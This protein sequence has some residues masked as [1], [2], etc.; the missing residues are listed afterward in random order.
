MAIVALER[1]QPVQAK[2][3]LAELVARAGS[4]DVVDEFTAGVLNLLGLSEEAARC[5]AR[6]LARHP[7]RIE[8]FLLW[9]NAMKAAGQG[10]LAVARFQV[11]TETAAEDDLFAVA[12][13]G[14]LNLGARPTVLQSALRRVRERIAL[15]P[16]K[17]FLYRLAA[18][19]LEAM[20]RM[21]QVT[22]VLEQS[23]VVAGE[24]RGPLLR[25][26]M[27]A[28]NADGKTDQA[29]AF[30]RT[31]MGLGE[32]VPPQV[33][34]DLGEALIK[35]DQLAAANRVF[36][37]ASMDADFTAIQQ[38]VA[39]AYETADM[40]E[41]ADR[42]IRELLIGQPD[43]VELLIFSGGLCEQI[44]G[45]SRAFEQ[46]HRAAEL[47]LRRLPT[48][49]QTT[50]ATTAP[51][52]GSRRKQ[53]ERTAVN[54]DEMSQYFDS[55]C[56][57]L[58][59]S[60]RSKALQERLIRELRD[61][62]LREIE[63]LASRRMATSSLKQ[64]PRLDGLAKFL[65][66]VAF[67][68]HDPEMADEID[69]KLLAIYSKDAGLLSEAIE[70]RCEWGLYARASALAGRDAAGPVPA[71][72]LID[73]LLSDRER[74]RTCVAGGKVEP[75]IALRLLPTLIM[76]GQ[77]DLARQLVGS[78]RAQ[79]TKP[80]DD[81]SKA[82][83][84]AAV[85]LEDREAIAAWAQTSLDLCGKDR[86]G[87]SMARDIEQTLRLSWN[88]LKPEE[89]SGLIQR[90]GEL[91]A[92]LES[93]GR[94]SMDLL[95]LRLAD[96]AKMPLANRDE[97]I[98]GAMKDVTL[99]ADALAELLALVPASDRPAMLE[100]LVAARKP[101]TQRQFLLSMIGDLNVDED[102]PLVSAV[103]RAFRKAPKSR[104][105]GESGYM[106]LTRARWYQNPRLPKS[107]LKVAEVLLG[108]QPEDPAVMTVVAVARHHGGR[109]VE[110]LSLAAE[111][112]ETITSAKELK[113]DDERMLAE[114]GGIMSPAELDA[115]VG[116][117]K[118]RQNLEGATPGLSYAR[119]ALLLA[120]NRVQEAVAALQEGF[121]LAPEQS[122][123]SRRL[124][125]VMKE[126]GRNVELAE[127][128]AAHLT[129]STIMQ[130]YQ[131]MTLVDTYVGLGNLS[132]ALKAAR[133]L[134]GPLAPIH[135][136]RIAA[137]MDDHERIVKVLRRF[138]IQ[139]RN[140]RRFY[141]P[142]WPEP[143]SEGGMRGFLARLD[144]PRFSRDRIFAALADEP[145]AE[146]EFTCLLQAGAPGRHDIRGL[147]EGLVRA[148]QSTGHMDRLLK[149]LLDANRR[150]AVNAKDQLTIL[151]IAQADPKAIP[152]DLMGCVDRMLTHADPSDAEALVTLARLYMA[153]GNVDR[154]RA[155]LGWVLASDRLE[156]RGSYRE[157]SRFAR[158][159]AYVSTFRPEE[160]KERLL[161]ILRS[162]QPAPLD[163]PADTLDS[164][165]LL[166]LADAADPA[167]VN[168]VVETMRTR[169]AGSS[170]SQT[171][172][173][174]AAI[175]R[176]DAKAGRFEQFLTT[177]AGIVEGS[178]EFRMIRV[179]FDYR[180][181][182]PPAREMKDPSRYVQGVV[183]CLDKAA[184]SKRLEPPERVAALALLG[185]WCV[186]EG[187]TVE[188]GA[189]LTRAEQAA[190]PL[191]GDWLWAA[192]LAASVGQPGKAI[193]IQVRL[194]NAR[195]LPGPRIPGLLK[196]VETT[197]SQAEADRLAAVAASFSDNPVVLQ[198]AIRQARREGKPDQ[199][200][201]YESRLRCLSTRP[202][203]TQPPQKSRP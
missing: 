129:K 45:F 149:E 84:A 57:G 186:Q 24:R 167:E 87:P 35:T 132:E 160:Q 43:N 155:I 77:N 60:A 81:A 62:T 148:A 13:D 135:A 199:V 177:V 189:M 112:I 79:L 154:A 125:M 59:N 8:G 178:G 111:A 40:P 198:G 174:R 105:R 25:E 16:D 181:V 33:F 193:D 63:S 85:A 15:N 98:R 103:E 67:S 147:A 14:L 116:D 6:S 39:R 141:S 126:T 166:R 115:A 5:Y 173:L 170:V 124:I 82:V 36:R 19:L 55:A 61:W 138:L 83:F 46:Y 184:G 130:S 108:E 3:A 107:G 134:E 171:R 26:L 56:N 175:A 68:L 72:V 201:V 106:S 76:T 162:L 137:M 94:T 128:L 101:E 140:D 139:N 96:R 30:G 38:R 104:V 169:L 123:I 1:R 131:W 161:R 194:L 10:D 114:L 88:F 65:R 95:R 22:Q 49:V 54:L 92:R 18:D 78:L 11:L 187:L 37:R 158:I 50:Q 120:G 180:S 74:L 168:Q 196:A 66:Y 195:L 9:G 51:G 17:V 136:M 27:D 182:L 12:I 145:F 203:S 122:W 192:D 69:R 172:Q 163:G 71:P 86:N 29:I 34:I 97:I 159:D 2:A 190:G 41:R 164:M 42:V 113:Y 117:L 150:G 146:Q 118:A 100:S 185:Q 188:A 127:I 70:S 102:E 109:H 75:Q 144:S 91:G 152:E 176:L 31:L 151:L 143:L 20:G 32:E 89:R 52:K 99:P 165:L 202:T 44:G 4:S 119:A 110:A 156:G 197:R 179:P 142:F 133:R 7:D 153:R 21:A 58:L 157:G 80:M 90:I 73:R 191:G 47:M 53:P 48:A 93:P 23:V 200:K 28:A 183:S 121:R 64:N